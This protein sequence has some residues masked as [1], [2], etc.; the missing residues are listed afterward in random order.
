MNKLQISR[1]I[2]RLR[3]LCEL[4]DMRLDHVDKEY[5]LRRI[6]DREPEMFYRIAQERGW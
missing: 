6:R 5:V 1:A 2:S 3:K 4:W